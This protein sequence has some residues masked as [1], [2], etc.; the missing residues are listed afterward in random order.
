MLSEESVIDYA[1]EFLDLS[2]N[3]IRWNF[4]LVTSENTDSDFH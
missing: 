3:N 2:L 4:F 1:A